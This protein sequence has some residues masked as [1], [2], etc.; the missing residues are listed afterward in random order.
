MRTF[1]GRKR[2]VAAVQAREIMTELMDNGP[3][4]GKSIRDLHNFIVVVVDIM[5]NSD[6]TLT[7]S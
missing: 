2:I 4:Q 5:P 3:L 1:F 6:K 7:K